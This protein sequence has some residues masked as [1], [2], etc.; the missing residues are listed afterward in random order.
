MGIG[1]LSA[2]Q[3]LTVVPVRLQHPRSPSK[4]AI[5]FPWVGALLGAVAGT[6]IALSRAH[7]GSDIACLLA[8]VILTLLTG[9]IHEDGLAD[10]ADAFRA[11]RSRGK[12]LEILKDSR[13]GTYGALALLG[14]FLV[15]WQALTRSHLDPVLGLVAAL[16]LSR[17]SLVALAGFS[18]PLGDGLGSDF[19]RHL[20]RPVLLTSIAGSILIAGLAAGLTSVAMIVASAAVVAGLRL[21]FLRRA[22]GVNGDC[23]GA[24]CVIVETVN[25]LILAWQPST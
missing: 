11:G 9:G 6:W 18:P 25:L 2:L 17:A 10:V 21:Y 12:I 14:A 3:F 22:G 16:A 19:I 7:L 5:Y 15:R 8:L 4:S 20:S 24:T 13:I 1:F 23:L